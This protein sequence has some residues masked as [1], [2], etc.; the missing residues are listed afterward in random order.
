MGEGMCQERAAG[1]KGVCLADVQR[2][3]KAGVGR[4][5]AVIPDEDMGPPCA[6]PQLPPPPTNLPVHANPPQTLCSP[7][8][9]SSGAGPHTYTEAAFLY[10]TVVTANM[11]FATNCE[12]K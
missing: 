3:C 5:S 4:Q 2:T 6:S 11:L 7:A 12:G 1:E 10:V 9:L 8:P